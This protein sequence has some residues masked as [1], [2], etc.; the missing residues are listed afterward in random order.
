MSIG[1]YYVREL[2]GCRL[3]AGVVR[4]GVVRDWIGTIYNNSI[5]T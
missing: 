5:Y 3:I 1:E 2:L 4:V